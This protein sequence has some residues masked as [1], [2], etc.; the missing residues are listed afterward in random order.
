M[1]FKNIDK[2][3]TIVFDGKEETGFAVAPK[4][5]CPH[6]NDKIITFLNLLCT[7]KK[8]LITS[9]ACED[10]HDKSEN[11]L[12][13][14]CFKIFCARSVKEHMVNHNIQTKHN[15][16]LSFSDGSFWCYDCDSYIINT[17]LEE[18]QRSFGKI[19]FPEDSPK[20]KD[21]EKKLEDKPEEKKIEE[22]PKEKK[23]LE[24]SEENKAPEKDL[25]EKPGKKIEDL[26]DEL[27]ISAGKNFS[28][29]NFIEGIKSKKYGKILFLTGAGISV[30]AGIPDFRS[31]GTGLY[32][33]LQEYN[34]PY[35]EA[36]FELSYFKKNPQ[37]FYTLSK[38]FLTAEVHPTTSHFFQKMFEDLGV[39]L[40]SF[41]QNIDSLE[42]EAG[43]S[44]NKLCQAHGHL[45]TCHCVKCHKE[46]DA[47]IMMKS[48][49]TETILKCNC[50]GLV[51]PDIVFFGES[52]PLDFFK[53]TELLDNADL[54]IVMG[55]SL[56][57]FP[58][59]NLINLI[60][61]NV[62]IVLINREDS[63]SQGADL[64]NFLFLGGDLDKNVEKIVKDL[65][66]K[67][68]YEKIKNRVSNPKD[69]EIIEKS[70][71]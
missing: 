57:V 2:P 59:A 42:L 7:E 29:N 64:N 12:C 36:V 37:A 34:L 52:L 63:Y 56:K 43:L 51:K 28:Y 38:G 47:K 55:T 8:N 54:V 1:E 61:K 6:F 13:L 27:T 4:R 41:T 11:W 58:F 49:E 33:K 35:P 24:K 26:F 5:N 60:P 19:K 66:M 21:E 3:I 31:P 20:N 39:L 25:G 45:R 67:D 71:I 50:G 14:I 62:P 69:K 17:P 16:V 44:L 68:A 18:L 30:S 48:I 9:N 40:Q 10:C 65:G 23:L 32:S 15:I 46:N 22:K 53:K 70:K